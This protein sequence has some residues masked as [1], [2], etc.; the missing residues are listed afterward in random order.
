MR[1]LG[2]ITDNLEKILREMV[3]EHEMQ[4]HEIIGMINAYLETHCPECLENYTDGTKLKLEW[5]FI[6]ET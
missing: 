2:N 5:I 6:K 4:R 1:R 3:G